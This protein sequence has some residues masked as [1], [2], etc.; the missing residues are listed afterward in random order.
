MENIDKWSRLKKLVKK[1]LNTRRLFRVCVFAGA[2]RLQE[3]HMIVVSDQHNYE[4]LYT[5]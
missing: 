3:T 1:E 5:D 4:Q 2:S